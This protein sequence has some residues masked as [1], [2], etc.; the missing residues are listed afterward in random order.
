[1]VGG[2]GEGIWR[3]GGRRKRGRERGGRRNEGKESTVW[4]GGGSEV[5][6]KKKRTEG[7]WKEER[8]NGGRFGVDEGKPYAGRNTRKR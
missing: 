7:R 3:K 8:K 1:M 5:W 6:S 2:V 4:I